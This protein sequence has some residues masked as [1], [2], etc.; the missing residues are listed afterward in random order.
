M[1]TDRHGLPLST[2][3]ARA[4]DAYV[5]GI[6]HILAATHGAAEAFAAAIAADPG[7]AL[8][9][10]GLARAA[11]YAADMP[12][13]R[14]ALADAMACTT[15][16]TERETSHLAV[17]AHL[18]AGR[19]AKARHAALAHSA[20]WPGD[21][22]VAQTCTNIFGL[23]GTSG[24]PG[25]ESLQLAYTSRLHDAL[26]DDWWVLSVHGQ[27]LCETG[28]LDDAMTMMDRSLALNP[29]NANA[30]HFRAHTLYEQGEGRTGRTYL[31]DWIEG[32]DR[33]ALL[34]GHLSWHRALW[35]LDDGDADD[36]WSIYDDAI[37]PE[38]SLS[39]PINILTDAAALLHRA[40]LAG[41]DVDPRH[42][43]KLSDY[44]ARFFPTPGMSFADI[45]AALAHAM[46][47]EGDRLAR[48]AEAKDGF[49][50][51]LVR[52]VARA[53]AAAA[54]QDWAGALGCLAPVMADHARLG[55]SR[56]QRD[57][58]ELTYLNLLLKCGHTDEARRTMSTRRPIFRDA[59]PVAG[60]A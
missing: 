4:R 17:F 35:A 41:L 16:L 14:A 43:R 54:R 30:S 36:L 31:A 3:S 9:H 45:H 59:A 1:H 53:W 21:V 7:F 24:E 12:G 48:L 26:G 55:G 49:A 47:G 28:R 6:D 5:T 60:Y 46:A 57:L 38:A 50:A 39:L 58:L 33:R 25:R 8:A 27:A 2:E 29:A 22:L 23:I 40:A 42:W 34:H 15:P 56:A 32:Y 13:A 10:V 52:P 20:S 11:M 51:D 18:V 44:A 19:A 37:A